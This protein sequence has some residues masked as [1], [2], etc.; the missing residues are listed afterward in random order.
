MRALR[1]AGNWLKSHLWVLALV[2]L[3]AG[4]GAG[5]AYLL[6]DEDTPQETIATGSTAPRVILREAPAA[7]ETTDLGFPAFATKNTTRVAAA[8]SGAV[9]AAVALAV[10]PSTGDVRGPAAVTLIDAEDWQSGIAAAS[11]VAEPIRAPVLITAGGELP[12]LTASALRELDPRG[13]AATAGRQ[14]FSLGAAARPDGFDSLAIEGDDPAALAAE[15][16]RLRE[17]LAGEP[18]HIVLVSTD[19]PSLAM[20]AAGW[21]ARSGDPVLFVERDSVPEPTREALR[22]YGDVPV[23]VLGPES[24]VSAKAMKEIEKLVPAV[25]RIGDEDPV[26]NAIEFATYAS[27]SFGWNINDPGH[28]FVIARADRP[29]DA[30]AA[31]PLSGSGTWGPLLVSDD[32]AAVPEA[33]DRYLLDLKPGYASNPTRAVYNHVWL[34]GDEDAL[35]VDFQARVDE[36]AELAPITSGSGVDTLGP[37]PG[38][39]ESQPEPDRNR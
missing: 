34:I 13:S 6:I 36:L 23:Y 17:R 26:T 16:D 9:A 14:V 25:A 22:R 15:I 19:E 35:S 11:L 32:G 31:A 7:E 29:L 12:E 3:A 24:A 20:P 4:A 1:S 30:A 10:H 33:L 39:P 5:G 38:T 27:G 18:S 37:P 21:A 2:V 28:G 8:D